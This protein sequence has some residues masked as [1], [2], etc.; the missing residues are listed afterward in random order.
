MTD[1]DV[2]ETLLESTSKFVGEGIQSQRNKEIYWSTMLLVRDLVQR[3]ASL[4]EIE[5]ALLSRTLDIEMDKNRDRFKLSNPRKYTL[6][7]YENAIDIVQSVR[8]RFV[9]GGFGDS[10]FS[11]RK[12]K[13]IFHVT[14]LGHPH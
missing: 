6:L 8:K 12:K 7:A 5:V 1:F 2:V 14:G 4:D 10:W 9:T 11:P 13:L 3:H